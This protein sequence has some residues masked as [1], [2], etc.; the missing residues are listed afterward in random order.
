MG[1]RAPHDPNLIEPH[2]AGISRGTSQKQD[3]ND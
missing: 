3:N 1:R 2:P